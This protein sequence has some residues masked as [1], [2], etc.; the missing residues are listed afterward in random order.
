MFF[1]CVCVYNFQAATHPRVALPARA[2]QTLLQAQATSV[3]ALFM[4]SAQNCQVKDSVRGAAS[5][6]VASP[7]LLWHAHLHLPPSPH[8]L[9][10][11]PR[12]F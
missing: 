7:F 11:L 4:G 5:L 6:L 3:P 10:A 2:L 1:L 12:P 8:L 9:S